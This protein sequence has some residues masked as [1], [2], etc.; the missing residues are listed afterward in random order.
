MTNILAVDIG[1]SSTKIAYGARGTP[2]NEFSTLIFPSIAAPTTRVAQSIGARE[3]SADDI[4]IWYE[5]TEY[6]ACIRPEYTRSVRAVHEDYYLEDTYQVL[7]RAALHLTGEDEISCVVTGLPVTQAQDTRRVN[8]L[9]DL[10]MGEIQTTKGRV[11]KVNDVKVVP[12]PVGAYLEMIAE[13]DGS[14]E[15]LHGNIIVIDPGYFSVDWLAI[16]NAR[17]QWD[18]SG[19]SLAAVSKVLKDASDLLT[20]STGGW[21]DPET[22]ESALRDGEERILSM[23][24]PQ[25]FKQPLLEA[26]KFH[27]KEAVRSV[28][29]ALREQRAEPGII[30][31]AGGGAKIYRQSVEESFPDWRIWTGRYP[32]VS[33]VRGFWLLQNGNN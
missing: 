1:Y 17:V 26:S 16:K 19:T 11:V 5:G 13:W 20:Q 32:A 6:S 29:T 10:M 15:I 25:P 9:R 33:N 12:Q 30:V 7:Y 4:K 27:A 31:M 22:I 28:R 18:A 3:N 23:G 14:R 2:A 21:V 24:Q 8:R